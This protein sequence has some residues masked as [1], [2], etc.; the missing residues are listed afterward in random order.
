MVVAKKTMKNT[1]ALL[2]SHLF[3]FFKSS[4]TVNTSRWLHPSVLL[5]DK[6]GDTIENSIKREL[7]KSKMIKIKPT[8]Q[9]GT[10]VERMMKLA[11]SCKLER[12]FCIA[13]KFWQKI[14]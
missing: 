5:A 6:Q 8:Y 1:A 13:L 4:N 11:I 9:K 2:S 12:K 10:V 14:L 7:S 3:T